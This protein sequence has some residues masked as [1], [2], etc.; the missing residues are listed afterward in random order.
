M[1]DDAPRS[2]PGLR[3]SSSDSVGA[4]LL[5]D[6]L[7]AGVPEEVRRHLDAL[8]TSDL[9]ARAACVHHITSAL[10]EVGRRW[11]RGEITTAHEH[12][13]TAM[14]QIELNRLAPYFGRRPAVRRLALLAATPG[15]LHVVGLTM[16]RLFLEGDGWRVLDL[17]PGMPDA[18]LAALAEER[19]PDVVGM[20]TA[21]TTHLA[22]AREAFSALRAVRPRPLIVAGGFAYDSD[23]RLA[24]DLGADAYLPDASAA[25]DFLRERF[26]DG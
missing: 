23:A 4:S 1:H 15:E 13:A 25:A 11:Q 10:R 24:I 2:V 6:L 20:S 19:R 9:T 18:D 22:A 17:G 21:L 12:L 8:L 26:R 7:I 5:A 16:L 3:A 14:A